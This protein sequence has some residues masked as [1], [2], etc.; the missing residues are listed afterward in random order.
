M[1][2]QAT[3]ANVRKKLKGDQHPIRVRLPLHKGQGSVYNDNQCSGKFD[4]HGR[5]VDIGR[6]VFFSKDIS[7]VSSTVNESEN[8]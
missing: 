6:S 4:T 1:V 7:K 5:N 8:D 2:F 3:Y